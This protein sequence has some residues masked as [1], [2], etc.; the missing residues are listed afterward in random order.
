MKRRLR[1]WQLYLKIV[2][3]SSHWLQIAF[4]LARTVEGEAITER[5]MFL[6]YQMMKLYLV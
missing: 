3:M 4:R 1:N 2:K 5:I 6:I